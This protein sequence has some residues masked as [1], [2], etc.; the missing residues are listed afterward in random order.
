MRNLI[1]IVVVIPYAFDLAEEAGLGFW[2]SPNLYGKISHS[3]VLI[4]FSS[5]DKILVYHKLQTC[6]V[7][8][9]LFSA[10]QN[11]RF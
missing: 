4:D 9:G 11:L 8:P 10:N 1:A 7:L 6:F 2:I 5:F 3:W